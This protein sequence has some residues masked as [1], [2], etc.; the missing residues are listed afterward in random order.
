MPGMEYVPKA[1]GFVLVR[2]GN[3]GW[4]YLLLTNAKHGTPGLPKGHVQ[5]GETEMET[6]LREA[7]EETGLPIL[8]PDPW[9]RTE[10]RYPVTR[11]GRAYEKTV[12]LFVART[13]HE[14]VLLSDEHAAYAW[15]PLYDA[16]QGLP[17]E[18]VRRAVREAALFLKDAVLFEVE[19]A[20]AVDAEEHLKTL[21]GA[22]E[23]LLAHVRGGAV[24]ARAFARQLMAAGRRVHEEATAAGALLH[25]AGRFLGRHRDHQL[26]GLEHLR[27]TALAPYGFACI[28]HFTKGALPEELARA[29]VDEETLA[30]FRRGVDLSTLTWEE[31]CVALADACMRQGD[32]TPPRVRFEDLRKR[33][34]SPAIVDLQERRTDAIRRTIEAASGEDPLKLVGLAG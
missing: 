33:Y 19:P 14:D 2:E 23:D 29:G 5:E 27:S 6:A 30:A 31:H 13:G 18:N 10:L 25:D 34:D 9:F 8:R 28:S 3:E 17:F 21:P 11:N 24:L 20:S 7:R 16:L 15:L 32:P 4:E 12:V 1:C 22:N 26:A